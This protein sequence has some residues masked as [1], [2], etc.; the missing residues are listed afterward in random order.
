MYCV[1]KIEGL[2]ESNYGLCV[3][4]E[5]LYGYDFFKNMKGLKEVFNSV[6]FF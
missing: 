2:M 5:M 3:F 6:R 4:K 1:V